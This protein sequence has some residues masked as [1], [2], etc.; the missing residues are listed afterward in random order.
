MG[1]DFA[2]CHHV[3]AH[4]MWVKEGKE[5]P[6][7]SNFLICFNGREEKMYTDEEVEDRRNHVAMAVMCSDI[8]KTFRDELSP[9]KF[10]KL[11]KTLTD[12]MEAFINGKSV[13]NFPEPMLTWFF[14]KRNHHYHEPNDEEFVRYVLGIGESRGR[15]KE[16]KK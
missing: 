6:Y 11:N 1:K 12:L 9:E 3:L 10:E 13:N 16:G 7:I 5:S 4:Q 14:N 15:E 2:P 8:F